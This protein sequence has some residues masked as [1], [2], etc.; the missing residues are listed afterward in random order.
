MTECLYE[1]MTY[2][3][4]THLIPLTESGKIKIKNHHEWLATVR[5]S[6]EYASGGM[7]DTCVLPYSSDVLL[8]RGKPVQ[9]H[10]GNRRLQAMVEDYVEEYHGYTR[11][12]QK[13]ELAMTITQRVLRAGGRFLTKESGIWI[14]V[15]DDI[16]RDKVS[17]LLRARRRH[18]QSARTTGGGTKTQMNHSDS[19]AGTSKRSRS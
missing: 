8:G 16:A 9:E 18:V 7:H 3:I 10:V 5:A 11:N 4:P 6:E 12:T 19:V 13:T 14:E 1:L 15:S 17:H 2:G